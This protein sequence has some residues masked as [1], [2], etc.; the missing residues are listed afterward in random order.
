MTEA[1]CPSLRA[2]LPSR[3]VPPQKASMSRAAWMTLCD[4]CVPYRSLASESRRDLVQKA[5]FRVL[6]Q[7]TCIGIS[8]L[9][10]C[11]MWPRCMSSTVT[12]WTC[13]SRTPEGRPCRW[14]PA[15]PQGPAVGQALPK[16]RRTHRREQN[17]KRE[18]KKQKVK[19]N[20]REKAPSRTFQFRA[21]VCLDVGEPGDRSRQRVRSL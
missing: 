5:D 11:H 21:R 10:I 7:T 16:P 3:Q 8:G 19:R 18:T 9:C 15:T 6:M 13:S 17:I 14:P 2:Y 4:K 20:T 1:I 12:L